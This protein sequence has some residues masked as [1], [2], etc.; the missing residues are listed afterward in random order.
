M[1]KEAVGQITEQMATM[2]ARLG[3]MSKQLS[4]LTDLMEAIRAHFVVSPAIF[5]VILHPGHCHSFP[6]APTGKLTIENAT[7]QDGAVEMSW[8]DFTSGGDVQQTSTRQV[9]PTEW[10][11]TICNTGTV[12]LTVCPA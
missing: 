1:D 7:D 6:S 8:G 5:C 4:K 9:E 11:A 2:A 10:P 3:T 12:P